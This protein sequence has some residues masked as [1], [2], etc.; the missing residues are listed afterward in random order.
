MSKRHASPLDPDDVL[1]G[2]VK[3]SAADLLQLIHREN[4]TGRELPAREAELRYARKARLQS[5]LVRRFAGELEVALDPMQP[6]TVS[7]RHR[8]HG[9]DGCH[10]VLA[11]LDDDAR[12]W[13]QCELD[14]AASAPPSAAA[15]AARPSGRGAAQTGQ[16]HEGNEAATPEE[17]VRRAEAALES[18]DYEGAR[19]A[20]ER[21]LEE[22]RG[23]AEPAAA[24]LGLLVDT[25]GDDAGALVLEPRIAKAALVEARVRGPLALA[26]AR[27]GQEDR[28]LELTRGLADAPAATVLAALAA[29]ALSAGDMDRATEHVEQARR[30]D[31]ACPEIR[32]VADELAKARAKACEP[33]EAEIAALLAAGRELEAE[34]KA[35]EVLARW[36]E[37]AAA[38]R[39][40]RDIE[41]RRRKIEAARL[42]AE[43]EDAEARGDAA[44]AL[45]R[46]AQAAAAVRGPEREAIEA[47]AR[48][49][50][51][52]ERTRREEELVEQ[53]I[54]TLDAAD[55]REGLA[56]YTG[57][58]E[59]LRARVRARSMRPELAWIDRM[60]GERGGDR[61][62]VEAAT[63]IA[64]ARAAL[65]RDPQAAIALLAPH[66]VTLERVPEARR[67]RREAEAALRA[68]R[69]SQARTAI[70]TARAELA[71][72]SAADALARLGAASLRELSDEERAEAAAIEA[73]A[74]RVL[75]R[76]R[77][78]G[79]AW[80]LRT[81][82][83]L[84]EA[85]ALFEELTAQTDDA[86][87]RARWERERD[88][89]RA[90][91][92]R[93][94]RVEVN[95]EPRST[96]ELGRFRPYSAASDAPWWLTADGRAIV[97]ARAYE[98]WVVVRVL[99]RET[100]LVHPTILLRTPE[101]LS[102]VRT[103]VCGPTLW[104]T[105]ER[106]AL[107][108]IA[109]DGWEVR[110]F[111]PSADVAAPTDVVETALLVT[112][113]DPAAPRYF[114]VACRPR[115]A[116]LL[117]RLRVIDLAQR[118][119]VREVPEVWHAETM[120][121]LDEPRVV[122]L[123]EQTCTLR[124]PRGV[125]APH[126]RF[127]LKM[128]IH[129]IAAHP[130][131]EGFVALISD[132][133]RSDF[134]PRADVESTLYVATISPTGN[135]VGMARL[136]GASPEL[137][138]CVAAAR[139]SGLIHGI[140]NGDESSLFALTS[141]SD[142]HL[143][144]ALY[145][146]KISGETMLVQDAGARRI[147]ALA[148]HDHGVDAAELGPLPPDL[149]LRPPRMVVHIPGEHDVLSCDRPSGERNAAALALSAAWRGRSDGEVVRQARELEQAEKATP[150]QLV[151]VVF[152]L[153]TDFTMTRKKEVDRL[154]ARLVARFPSH[155]EVRLLQ[156]NERAAAGQ[157]AETREAL[158]GVEPG[159][160]DESR[161]QH[162]H[163]LR[164]LAA[165][166]E[167]SFAEADDEVT[168][169]LALEGRCDLQS[170]ADLT[171]AAT[172]AIHADA[173]SAPLA[174]LVAAIEVADAC[175][176]AHDHAGARR[177][178]DGPV[179][180]FARELQSLARLAEAYLALTPCS[181]AE[182]LRK[183]E[184]LGTLRD[185]LDESTS[186]DGRNLLIPGA[187][188]DAR[189]ADVAARARGWLDA[190]GS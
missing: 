14:L 25:L 169:A 63:A 12:S 43:A 177:A 153:L 172:R 164:A 90:E 151:A 6:G 176:A 72:G 180:W 140:T 66:E 125:V 104:L 120:A 185:H 121:G 33:A 54:R 141:G 96:E 122:T 39:A 143:S 50:E 89:I 165:L 94:F 73:A 78:E 82:G 145:A 21:A 187:W 48:T 113:E 142:H 147:V 92:Q 69:I 138:S 15:P 112:A 1:A 37:S 160:F 173:E 80:R 8:G 32:G 100:M 19:E 148:A 23:A 76:N 119:A 139:G 26:A 132:F 103:T 9:R 131:G 84:F 42:A 190:Q 155:P 7:L 167:G 186:M 97:I 144:E 28:A 29:S 47:R 156:A 181:Y 86:E 168:A 64:E 68:G 30:R 77:R 88:A 117:E 38:R 102:R 81:T 85:R 149:P 154:V 182:H 166:R 35:G 61:A 17:L 109:M 162:L 53:A 134:D 31:P 146:V 118:R 87:E 46:L 40:L 67:I 91:I 126:G 178:L 65:T 157:W 49:I 55:P 57:L 130:S 79:E 127:E 152:A 44:V 110:D 83:R 20:L 114:W 171:A 179:V 27:S 3:P 4:P 129:E 116:S 183:L 115:G 45:A 170:I 174:Q 70:E 93:N 16:R 135:I 36:P 18:Y 101:P 188:D 74:T 10:A 60:V 108:E 107:V 163:H 123:I 189:L 128:G 158:A 22:S 137:A 124:T 51:A 56:L 99:N 2:R 52:A 62:K 24:L 41:E 59:A 106:G 13:A 133:L 75:E 11:A 58:E 105:G 71:A 95:D 161:A 98:R 5:L 111:R 34:R 136:P 150:E 184:T 159:D 175:F